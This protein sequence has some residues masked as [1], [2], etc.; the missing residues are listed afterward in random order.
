VVGYGRERQMILIDS[1]QRS[2]LAPSLWASWGLKSKRAAESR[3]TLSQQIEQAK[4]EA[5]NRQHQITELLKN[6]D[7]NDC[8]T[9]TYSQREIEKENREKWENNTRI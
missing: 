5:D 7:D 2:L 3:D 1:V 6:K 9:R 4:N 8:Q